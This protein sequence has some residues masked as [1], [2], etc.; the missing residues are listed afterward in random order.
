MPLDQHNP[1]VWTPTPLI[2]CQRGRRRVQS[3]PNTT[4]QS[5]HRPV[6]ILGS[7][8]LN[9]GHTGLPASKQTDKPL[10]LTTTKELGQQEY[11]TRVAQLAQVLQR[12]TTQRET[13]IPMSIKRF[14]A[15][16]KF[17]QLGRDTG[18]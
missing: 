13:D 5:G 10:A 14:R 2:L 12:N 17:L 3:D 8:Y 15:P 1:A 9:A 18:L 11:Q 6:Y 16:N 4:P 7:N